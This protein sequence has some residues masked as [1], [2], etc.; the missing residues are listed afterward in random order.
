MRVRA[1]MARES[2][3]IRK[4]YGVPGGWV[5]KTLGV[6]ARGKRQ[7]EKIIFLGKC[8]LMPGGMHLKKHLRS[9]TEFSSNIG[10]DKL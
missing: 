6:Y 3:V 4:E 10:V 1:N 5:G 2:E 7:I 9:K 8:D